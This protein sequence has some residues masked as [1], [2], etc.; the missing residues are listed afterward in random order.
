MTAALKKAFAKASDLPQQLQR[1]LARQWLEDI[2]AEQEW[3]ST[4]AK[5]QPLLERMAR[6]ALRDK[7][8]GKVTRQGFDQL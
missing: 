8:A 2:S 5:S 7:K 6:K 4:L 1:Q 3:D